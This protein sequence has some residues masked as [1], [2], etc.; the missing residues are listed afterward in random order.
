MEITCGMKGKR[1]KKGGKSKEY[2]KQGKQTKL[3]KSVP[4]KEQK[5]HKNNVKKK[6]FVRERESIKWTLSAS[7]EPKTTEKSCVEMKA[8]KRKGRR[9]KQGISRIK[10]T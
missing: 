4:K 5:T 3:K 8:E 6:K 7:K 1:E 2:W 9:K 10:I